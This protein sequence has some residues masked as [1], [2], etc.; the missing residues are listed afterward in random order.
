MCFNYQVEGF[1]VLTPCSAVEEYQRFGGIYCLH[2]Q[3]EVNDAEE[4]GLDFHT[5][6]SAVLS[7]GLLDNLQ[8]HTL[9]I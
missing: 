8:Q 6:L 5:Q 1:R 4:R 3:G 9:K 2:L 7:A